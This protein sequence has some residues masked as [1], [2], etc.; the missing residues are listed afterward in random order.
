MQA[1]NRFIYPGGMEGWVDLLDLIATRPGV[2]SATFRSRVQRSTS[3]TTKT[4]IMLKPAH[5]WSNVCFRPFHEVSFARY[6][7]LMDWCNFRVP[8]CAKFKILRG[9]AAGGAYSTP[10]LPTVGGGS[11]CP[12]PKSSS[13]SRP[14]RPRASCTQHIHNFVAW[15]PLWLRYNSFAQH[16][17][18]VVGS[19]GFHCQ[20]IAEWKNF[21]NRSNI[22]WNYDKKDS[23][24]DCHQN[25]CIV[26]HRVTRATSTVCCIAD[27]HAI[28][29]G[30]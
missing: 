10:T 14:F 21:L 23:R 1:S 13:P 12:L 7:V 27:G 16:V 20:Y 6:T 15:H 17:W 24:H 19:L 22:W 30:L 18:V 11:R 26:C 29:P 25:V 5:V 4:T 28:T 8:K 9:Y 3:A 2:E